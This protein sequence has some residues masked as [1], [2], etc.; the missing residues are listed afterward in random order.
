MFRSGDRTRAIGPSCRS[1]PRARCAPQEVSASRVLHPIRKSRTLVF[2][3]VLPCLPPLQLRGIAE[4]GLLKGATLAA[5]FLG[6][7]C[8]G[9]P[10][11]CLFVRST[12][13]PPMFETVVG[14][15]RRTRPE[16]SLLST[17]T[18]IDQTL[19][20]TVLLAD[21]VCQGSDYQLGRF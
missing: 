18:T 5:K 11:F 14:C 20:T 17:F 10:F 6:L 16:A 19:T 15:R 12:E 3:A 13:V 8:L 2:R 4:A 21:G 1:G 7:W 9:L